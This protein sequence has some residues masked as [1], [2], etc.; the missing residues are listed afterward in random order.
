MLRCPLKVITYIFSSDK[1]FLRFPSMVRLRGIQG[2]TNHLWFFTTMQP[3]PPTLYLGSEADRNLFHKV[4]SYPNHVLH[5]LL[6][7]FSSIS[8]TYSLRPRAHDRVLPQHST[9]LTDC[10]FIIRLLC[11][12]VYWLIYRARLTVLYTLHCFMFYCVLSIGQNKWIMPMVIF[13]VS[14][15][16]HEFYLYHFVIL[17]RISSRWQRTGRNCTRAAPFRWRRS[18][19]TAGKRRCHP[20][21]T[22]AQLR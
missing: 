15:S 8:Q 4:L 7:P 1:A 2:S 18:S 17:Y 11:D 3:N 16:R 10:N 12:E 14:Y 21:Y 6:P 5:H 19:R 20:E 22:R 13:L 9:R